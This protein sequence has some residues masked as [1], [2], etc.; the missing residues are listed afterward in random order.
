MVTRLLLVYFVVELL[1]LVALV[2]TIGF[3][4][5]VLVLL[6]TFVVGL[7]LAGSQVRRQLARL[8]SEQ[9]WHGSAAD[10][11][12]VALGTIMVVVPGLVTSVA[13]VLLLLP[14][15]RPVAR[16]V[17]AAITVGGLGRR[18][19]LVTATA[20]SAYRYASR[21]DRGDYIDAE[22]IDVTDAE[23]PAPPAPLTP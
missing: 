13:G 1:A 23:P 15:T 20:T 9:G 6:A 3:G 22:V 19:R 5:T 2:S 10:S 7:A 17:L 11:A 8:R 16:P 14:V 4:W 21:P 18:A 12:V